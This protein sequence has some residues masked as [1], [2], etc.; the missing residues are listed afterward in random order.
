M[1][2]SISNILP[3]SLE[4][5][6][7]KLIENDYFPWFYRDAISLASTPEIDID[8][9]KW[10]SSKVTVP[11]G[12]THGVYDEENGINSNFFAA[13]RSV[14]YFLEKEENF[15]IESLIRIRIRRTLPVEGHTKDHYNLP[16]VD[17]YDREAFTTFV[18]YVDDSDGDT[19]IFDQKHTVGSNASKT[20]VLKEVY[21]STPKKGYGLLFDGLQYHAGNSPVDYKTRTIINFDFYKRS[22][23]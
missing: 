1:F 20:Q 17:F 21:R 8:M 2:K 23:E 7:I 3:K 18:Y 14:L 16:H 9:P 13:A 19:I 6:I 4:D 12:L 11:H 10:D 22:K 15:E 5:D